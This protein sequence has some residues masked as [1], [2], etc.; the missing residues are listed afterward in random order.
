M[1]KHKLFM[2]RFPGQ[3]Q[4]HPA[5]SQWVMNQLVKWSR[6]DRISG[7]AM[8][9]KSDTPI[10]M[11]RNQMAKRALEE[12]CDYIC[13]IDA[14]IE[15]DAPMYAGAKPFWESSWEF[16]MNHRD[17]PCAI[18]SPYCGPPPDEIVYMAEWERKETYEPN[19]IPNL[20]NIHRND[21]ARRSGIQKVV[22]LP[23]GL[24]II[25]TRLFRHIPVP[26]FDYEFNEDM[27]EKKTTEDY[28]FTRNCSL[29]GFPMYCNW[30]A[31]SYHWK[32]KRVHPPSLMCPEDVSDQVRQACNNLPR[33]DRVVFVGQQ[34]REGIKCPTS[35]T[36]AHTSE[37]EK[38]G[39][40]PLQKPPADTQPPQATP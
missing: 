22:G 10:T 18:A 24:I 3:M 15:P 7:V 1:A 30:D 12:E 20:I 21:A 6:D 13:M 33:N 40:S 38:E 4:E 5:S 39:S 28:F 29:A 16:L 2:A 34:N 19:K 9:Y 8:G 32:M 26:W 31:W 14:D 36:K 11:V 25:D 37:S 35:A 23:T 17:V 27:T